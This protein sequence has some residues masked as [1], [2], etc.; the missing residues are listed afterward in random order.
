[1]PHPALTP[2][3]QNRHAVSAQDSATMLGCRP[4]WASRVEASARPRQLR[5]AQGVGAST[6]V[7]G[8]AEA[9]ERRGRFRGG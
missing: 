1:M 4:R 3:P 7:G 9:S 8:A 6:A 5:V 2:I